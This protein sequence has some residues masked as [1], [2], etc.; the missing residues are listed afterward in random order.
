MFPTFGEAMP[1]KHNK[2]ADGGSDSPMSGYYSCKAISGG[3][4]LDGTTKGMSRLEKP[5]CV[6]LKK[7]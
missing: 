1:H 4:C 7:M 6:F 3:C 2:D 5:H